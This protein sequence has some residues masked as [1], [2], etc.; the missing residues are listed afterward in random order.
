MSYLLPY[1]YNIETLKV[2]KKARTEIDKLIAIEGMYWTK[3][4]NV[5]Y[6]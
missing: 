3:F 1:E 4:N 5:V 6:M 2:H